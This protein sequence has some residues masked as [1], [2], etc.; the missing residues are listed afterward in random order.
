MCAEYW[1]LWG[2]HK[3]A[4]MYVKVKWTLLHLI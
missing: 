2:A 4:G 1:G 3:Y